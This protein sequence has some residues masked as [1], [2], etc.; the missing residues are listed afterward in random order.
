MTTSLLCMSLWTTFTLYRG[1]CD[2]YVPCTGCS[3]GQGVLGAIFACCCLA[4]HSALDCL[5]AAASVRHATDAGSALS[6]QCIR[7]QT[8]LQRLNDLRSRRQ[9]ALARIQQPTVQHVSF[10]VFDHNHHCQ[11][12]SN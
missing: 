7:L 10:S 1:A 4:V 2:A 11:Y 9:K 6:E 5:Q 8:A 3:H 12:C